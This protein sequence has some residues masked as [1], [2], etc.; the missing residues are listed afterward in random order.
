MG[1]TWRLWDYFDHQARVLELWLFS[2]G[3][4]LVRVQVYHHFPSVL[5]YCLTLVLKLYFL[6]ELQFLQIPYYFV[7]CFLVGRWPYFDSAF[8]G[9]SRTSLKSCRLL[10]TKL[11]SLSDLSV[12]FICGTR[13]SRD[14]RAF[15]PHQPWKI[16]GALPWGPSRVLSRQRSSSSLI[17]PLPLK[18]GSRT[19]GLE[20][21]CWIVSRGEGYRV[22]WVPLGVERVTCMTAT[23]L[24]TSSRNLS[25]EVVLVIALTLC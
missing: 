8:T 14:M 20:F 25:N 9:T 16:P 1:D 13:V 18:C 7:V 4:S 24:E 12:A 3:S 5:R 19:P 21:R 22:S 10:S 23:Y 11:S 6:F 2:T 17:L 15:E